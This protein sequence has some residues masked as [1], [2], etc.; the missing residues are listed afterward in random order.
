MPANLPPGFFMK[1]V[2]G[3]T[4]RFLQLIVLFVVLVSAG[5]LMGEMGLTQKHQLEEKRASLVEENDS[6]SSDI[7]TL[8]RQVTLLRTDPRT[9]EKVAKCKLGMARSDE[10]IYIF[11]R[12][13]WSGRGKHHKV[14]STNRAKRLK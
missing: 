13:Y 5:L 8:E 12:R 6:L 7:K 1:P 2:V 3:R 10:T 4:V 11:K 9:I 14:G